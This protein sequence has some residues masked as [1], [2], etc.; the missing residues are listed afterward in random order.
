MWNRKPRTLLA[1][2]RWRRQAEAKEAVVTPTARSSVVMAK[3]NAELA[4]WLRT[5][6]YLKAIQVEDGDVTMALLLLWEVEHVRLF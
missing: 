2:E 3:V 5:T 4:V 1:V 6:P